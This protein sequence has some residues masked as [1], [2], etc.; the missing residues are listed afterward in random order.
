MLNRRTLLRY[1]AASSC[2]VGTSQAFSQTNRSISGVWNS[3]YGQV[4]L[5]VDPSGA[6]TG[7][8][9][10]DKGRGTITGGQYDGFA[11]VVFDYSQPWNNAKGKAALRLSADGRVLT[12]GWNE[13]T[14][15]GKGMSSPPEQAWTLTR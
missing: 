4:T 13:Q 15:D 7:F 11:V 5:N 6:V 8:W 10:G 14:P 3:N 1:F 9:I 12:G 2:V